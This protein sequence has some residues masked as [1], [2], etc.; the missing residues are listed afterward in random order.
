MEEP[1]EAALRKR[2]EWLKVR[3]RE[4]ARAAKLVR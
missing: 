4:A 3:L 1:S 2:F